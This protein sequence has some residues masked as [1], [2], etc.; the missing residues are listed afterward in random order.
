MHL[1]NKRVHIKHF[2]ALL[3]LCVFSIALMPWDSLHQHEEQPDYCTQGNK[4][5][6][7]KSHIGSERH[8]CQICSVHFI[9]AYYMVAFSYQMGLQS[10][11]LL[12][13]DI[14]IRTSYTALIRASLR[15]PP[16]C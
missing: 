4:V 8:A 3:L 6:M 12:R 11:A 5:C 2:L 13:K 14:L 16:A 1:K 15:G 7:H 9:K 10:K